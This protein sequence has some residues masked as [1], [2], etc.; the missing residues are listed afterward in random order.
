MM[1]ICAQLPSDSLWRLPAEFGSHEC[2]YR[3]SAHVID[4]HAV[5]LHAH[6]WD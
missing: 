2:V 5:V 3:G 4:L 6:C 1:L